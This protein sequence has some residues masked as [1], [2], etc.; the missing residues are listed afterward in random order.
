MKKYRADYLQQEKFLNS[1]MV[2]IIWKEQLYLCLCPHNSNVLVIEVPQA[3]NCSD[4]SKSIS[5]S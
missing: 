4:S 5:Y 1:H 2:I 3:M